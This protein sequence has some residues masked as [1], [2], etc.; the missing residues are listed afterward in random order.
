MPTLDFL[1][2]RA[3]GRGGGETKVLHVVLASASG[4]ALGLSTQ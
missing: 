1:S 4:R 3:G 2:L